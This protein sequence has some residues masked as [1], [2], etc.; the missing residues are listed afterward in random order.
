MIESVSIA[1]YHEWPLQGLIKCAIIEDETTYKIT[2]Q[3]DHIPEHL[4]AS[5]LSKTLGINADN[6]IT[7]VSNTVNITG[8]DEWEVNT[9]LA[10]RR[11]YNK[12]EYMAD[13]LGVDEDLKYYPASDFKYS[14]HKIRDFHLA[15]PHLPGPPE[16]LLK[17]TR[18]W[19]DGVDNYDELTGSKEMS[20][21][22]RAK[23]F[24]RRV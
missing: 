20:Q 15:H 1:E 10:V 16:N 3:L 12:L 17:W 4:H 24:G 8:E 19:E 22:S 7:D 9:I 5:I 6:M 11:R 13:W 14:P 2:L 21:N 23:F 18:K